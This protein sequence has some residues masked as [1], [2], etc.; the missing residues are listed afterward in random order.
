MV[1]EGF[2]RIELQVGHDDE[3]LRSRCQQRDR[4]EILIRVVRQCRIQILV[5]R[6]RPSASVTAQ[7]SRSANTVNTRM[8]ANTALMSKVPSACRIRYPTPRDE[9]R[10]SPTTAPTK[11]RPTELCRLANTQLIALGT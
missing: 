6:H 2:E 1:D 4:R 3:H 9:P 7:A 5:R 8:P 11:A 10:Y